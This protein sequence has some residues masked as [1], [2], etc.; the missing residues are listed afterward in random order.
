[1]LAI[2]THEVVKELRAAGFSEDQAEA[3]TRVVRRAQDIDLSALSTK[4]DLDWHQRETKAEFESMRKDTKAQFDIMR[5]DL[6]A[7]LA[8]TKSDLLKWIVGAT[9]FQTVAILG[10][11]LALSHVLKP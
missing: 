4:I 1:M 11:V 9:G 5:R 2:D 7:G 6:S 8:E 10:A 3:V